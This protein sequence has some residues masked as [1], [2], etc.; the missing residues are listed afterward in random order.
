MQT[1]R[2]DLSPLHCFAFP[3]CS[4]IRPFSSLG[5][6]LHS[7]GPAA[8]DV[9]EQPKMAGSLTMGAGIEVLAKK[10]T[11]GGLDTE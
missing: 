4:D 1:T 9:S 3:A 11:P 10:T 6:S 8:Y 2:G 5:C 7:N